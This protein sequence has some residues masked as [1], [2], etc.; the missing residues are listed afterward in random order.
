MQPPSGTELAASMAELL[1]EL[2]QAGLAT[3]ERLVRD[4]LRRLS[5]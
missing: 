4:V 5:G 2:A 1:G 3:G